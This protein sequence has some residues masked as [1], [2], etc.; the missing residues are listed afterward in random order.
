M[1]TRVHFTYGRQNQEYVWDKCIALEDQK[2]CRY[3]P[4]DK[5]LL[6]RETCSDLQYL[7]GSLR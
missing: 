3:P 2:F 1:S 6:W 5:R 7:N 4:Y